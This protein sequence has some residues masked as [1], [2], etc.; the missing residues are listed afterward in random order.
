MSTGQQEAWAAL[1]L[2]QDALSE[3]GRNVHV[4]VA[5]LEVLRAAGQLAGEAVREASSWRVIFPL[6]LAMLRDASR[7]VAAAALTTIQTVS[8]GNEVVHW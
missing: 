8:T 6:L 1:A 2:V 3:R 5:T 4:T 7:P